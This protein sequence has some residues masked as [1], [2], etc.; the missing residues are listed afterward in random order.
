MK[1][2]SHTAA[3]CQGQDRQSEDQHCNH[4]LPLLVFSLLSVPPLLLYGGCSPFPNKA[5]SPS[6]TSTPPP[7]THLHCVVLLSDS[8]AKFTTRPKQKL[9]VLEDVS[10]SLSPSLH[11]PLSLSPTLFYFPLSVTSVSPYSY[12]PPW[13][14]QET[15]LAAREN[16]P[17]LRSTQHVFVEATVLE[18]YRCHTI[19]WGDGGVW[20]QLEIK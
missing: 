11:A 5:C 9:S 1:S 4:F 3:V 7:L 12:A 16:G 17:D 13:R 14:P 8:Q 6:M 10:L 2:T 19:C 18:R 15:H 20:C